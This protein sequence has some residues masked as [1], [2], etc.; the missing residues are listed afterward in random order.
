M[1]LN[2]LATRDVGKAGLRVFRRATGFAV[3]A[4]VTVIY[5]VVR[6]TGPTDLGRQATSCRL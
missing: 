3:V 1:R 2:D 6:A 4:T 5:A